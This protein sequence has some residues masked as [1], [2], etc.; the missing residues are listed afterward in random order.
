AGIRYCDHWL[1]NG[2]QVFREACK[3]GFEG[4]VSKRRDAPYRGG[5][6]PTWV[7]AKCTQRQELVVGGFTPSEGSDHAIG[8]LLVGRHDE[9][10]RLVFA[11]KVGTGYTRALAKQLRETLRPLQQDMPPFA[12][13]PAGWLRRG[14]RWV[15]PELVAEV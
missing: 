12:D 3:L 5:R 10:G 8:A 11:G 6:G 15:R 2:A 4:L 14:A 9:K 13:P 1:G 7:K